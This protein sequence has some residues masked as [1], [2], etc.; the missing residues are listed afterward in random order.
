M[1]LTAQNCQPFVPNSNSALYNSLSDA[2]DDKQLQTLH[3][4]P[5]VPESGQVYIS[6][7]QLSAHF[8][9]DDESL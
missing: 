7:C 8:A 4:L 5:T 9:S 3:Q 1:S 2:V 6:Y